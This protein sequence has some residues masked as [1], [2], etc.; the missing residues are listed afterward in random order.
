MKRIL[1]ILS[2]LMLIITIIN[3]N[4]TYSKYYT[5]VTGEYAREIGKW[6]IKIN[7]QEIYSED[8]QKVTFT[9]EPELIE[10]ENVKA[11]KIAPGTEIYADVDIN[12]SGTDV[13]IKY[14]VKLNEEQLQDMPIGLTV[15]KQTE[16]NELIQTGTNT[17]TGII[18]LEDVTGGKIETIRLNL[19]W[20]NDELKNESDTEIGTIYENSVGIPIEVTVTQYLGEEITPYTNQE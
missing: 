12:P 6:V 8:G 11:G 18:P 3:I 14:E 4:S 10:K 13:A 7:E 15:Q 20:I 16:G 9:I 2:L 19:E 1:I 5:E 17:Y